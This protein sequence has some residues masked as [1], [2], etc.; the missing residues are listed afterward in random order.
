M[1]SRR[2]LDKRLRPYEV[3]LPSGEVPLKRDYIRQTLRWLRDSRMNK[4]RKLEVNDGKQEE[5]QQ[6]E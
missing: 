4:Q 1:S 2:K 3:G 6:P 5:Q